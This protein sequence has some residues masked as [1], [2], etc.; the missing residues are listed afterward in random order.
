MTWTHRWCGEVLFQVSWRGKS[1]GDLRGQVTWTIEVVDDSM[2][3]VIWSA[4]LETRAAA[5]A[6]AVRSRPVRKLLQVCASP[7]GAGQFWRLV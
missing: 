2:V 4:R 3:Q 5:H 6:D 1:S 7:H